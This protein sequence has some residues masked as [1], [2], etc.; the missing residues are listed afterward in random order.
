MQSRAEARSA[1]LEYRLR[2]YEASVQRLGEASNGLTIVRSRMS[3]EES[4]S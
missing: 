4:Q 2:K 1:E 3:L